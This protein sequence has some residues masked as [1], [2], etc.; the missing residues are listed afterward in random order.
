MAKSFRCPAFFFIFTAFTAFA[1]PPDISTAFS[2]LDPNGA[3]GPVRFPHSVHESSVNPDPA[4][5][6]GALEGAACTGCHHSVKSTIVAAEYQACSTC[7]GPDGRPDNPA[8]KEGIELS[9]REAAHR[10]C[11]GC[12]RATQARSPGV[13]KEVARTRC[14]DCHEPART[15][16]Q[17]PAVQTALFP[18][19]APSVIRQFPA[20][21]A[22]GD[23][24]PVTN[25]WQVDPPAKRAPRWYDPFHQNPWKGDLPVS[26][27]GRFLNLSAE[28]EMVANQRQLTGSYDTGNH[29]TNLFDRGNQWAERE[30]LLFTIDYSSQS[31][32]F[33]PAAWRVTVTP[34]FNFN[35]LRTQRNGIP[36]EDTSRGNERQKVFATVQ[37]AFTEFRLGDTPAVFPFLRS[38]TG[39]RGDSPYFDSTSVRAGTHPFVSDFRGFIFNDT[40]LGVRLFWNASANRYQFNLAGFG[41]LQKDVDSELNT[42]HSRGQRVLVANIYRQDTWRP[43]YTMQFS[44]HYNNDRG[45]IYHDQNGFLDRPS[46]ARLDAVYLGWAGEGHFGRLNL[47]HALYQA[48]GR[49]GHNFIANRA[50]TINA[51]MGAAE[52]SVTED[53][54]RFKAGFLYASGDKNPFDGR[55]RGFDSIMDMPEF[56]GGRFSFWNL[57]SIRLVRTAENLVSQNSLLPSLRSNKFAGE[58]NFVNPGLF[59][60]NA[61]VDADITP[62][63]R[64][65]ANWN[66]LRFDHTEP[67]SAVTGLGAID[68]KIGLDSGFGFRFRPL[69][70]D[71]VSIDTGYSFLLAGP[72][73]REIYGGVGHA[74]AVLHS[75]FIRLRLVY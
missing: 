25:R 38:A 50:V 17:N 33:H 24:E 26:G 45:G 59:L 15:A 11:I 58:S 6:H 8:D 41:M 30:S 67:I 54:L 49:D 66:Y 20:P 68:P 44:F 71:N 35:F 46:P 1:G 2:L 23:A 10:A 21:P 57:Q 69:L 65:V 61:G 4:F 56:A 47:T 7:H 27:P 22:A 60:Y 5:P 62:K 39:V 13:F 48:A 34:A 36:F 32:A 31:T 9:N 19:S 29:G 52:A 28:S 18:L 64:F 3:R 53:W 42:W 43:G 16:P 73:M 14:G 75:V 12:H 37:Q 55:G 63:V 51:Q 40:N 70:N 72:G 74:D